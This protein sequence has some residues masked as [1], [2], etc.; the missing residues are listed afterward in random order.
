[1]NFIEILEP[2]CVGGVTAYNI[3]DVK[4]YYAGNRAENTQKFGVELGVLRQV[5]SHNLMVQMYSTSTSMVGRRLLN[6]MSTYAELWILV[7]LHA[8]K[9]N[10]CLAACVSQV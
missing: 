3:Q 5:H 10:L 8:G 4:K 9:G 1:M 7:V 6:V 2:V